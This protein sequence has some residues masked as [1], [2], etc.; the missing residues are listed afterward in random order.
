MRLVV[1][2]AL[3]RQPQTVAALEDHVSVLLRPQSGA[4]E[5]G[6]AITLELREPQTLDQVVVV[7]VL[8]IPRPL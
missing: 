8:T 2:V 4:R 1:V 3:A 7:V 6:K 5:A